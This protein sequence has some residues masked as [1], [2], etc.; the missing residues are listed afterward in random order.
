MGR[1]FIILFISLS[2][3]ETLALENE[4]LSLPCAGCHGNRGIS[5]PDSTIPSI[6]G[7]ET[8]YFIQ[9]FYEYKND[10]REN[11]VMRI[12]AKGYTEKQIVEM[13]KYFTNIKSND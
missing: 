11:Y 4:N 3:L 12:I 9:A 8:E 13:S 7:L 1:I 6:A 2:F 5:H 10:I